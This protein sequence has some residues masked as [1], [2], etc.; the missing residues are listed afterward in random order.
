M[1]IKKSNKK[2]TTQE[3]INRAVQIHGSRYDYSRVIYK[4]SST[5]VEILCPQHGS[6]YPTPRNHVGNRSKCPKCCR[7]NL[8]TS[9]EFAEAAKEVHGSKYCY[10]R[11]IYTWML[12]KVE[13][14]CPTHGSFWQLPCMHLYGNGCQRCYGRKKHLEDLLNQFEVT[15]DGQYSYEKVT[16]TAGRALVEVTC[17]KHGGFVVRV[18]NHLS[19]N[20]CPKCAG[21]YSKPH[22]KVVRALENL[23]FKEKEDF[24]V[25]RRGMLQGNRKLQ[26]DIYFPSKNLAIE[27]DGTFWHG[28]E[29][30]SYKRVDPEEVK[31]REDLKDKLCKEQGIKLIRVTD[32][33]INKNFEQVQ[34]LLVKY[35]NT[36]PSF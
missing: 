23:G 2:L 20:G 4:N 8:K 16:T 6:F 36:I 33:Q 30:D 34:E 1:S 9:E 14:I 26:L 35:L 31:Q 18:R 7:R 21:V 17:P 22:R 28:R 13:I 5:K 27:V 15:H 3:F 24:L 32:L 11:A 25:N 19:G 10:S 29:V 12:A